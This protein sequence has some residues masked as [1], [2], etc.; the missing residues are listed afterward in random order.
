MGTKMYYMILISRILIRL[1][2]MG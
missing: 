1:T 2:W